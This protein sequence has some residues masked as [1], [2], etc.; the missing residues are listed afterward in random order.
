MY[1]L[2]YLVLLGCILTLSVTWA[3]DDPPVDSDASPGPPPSPVLEPEPAPA[4]VNED[5]IVDI[6]SGIV[7]TQRGE[8]YRPNRPGLG[9][10]Q[11]RFDIR[12]GEGFR[13]G[14]RFAPGKD[15]TREGMPN[16][17]L[18]NPLDPITDDDL[19][20]DPL[21]EAI[22]PG[23]WIGFA[24]S[25]YK[26]IRSPVKDRN[27]ARELCRAL[28][29]DLV[30]VT[31]KTEHLFL[32]IQLQSN[33][34]HHRTWY[35]SGTQRTTDVWENDG[36][37]TSFQDMRDAILPDQESTPY[38]NFLA[39]TY[40][41]RE[42]E[43]GLLKVDGSDDFPFICEISAN[44]LAYLIDE[45]L[46]HDHSYGKFISDPDKIPRGPTIV[47]QPELRPFDVAQRTN[48]NYISVTCIAEGY[49]HPKYGWYK[50]SYENDVAVY[51]EIDPLEDPRFTVS[52]GTLIINDPKQV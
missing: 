29:A 36:D 6:D 3:Q 18:S 52:G 33:D 46:E 25:C 9:Y 44:D 43:W 8:A 39:Y 38:K 47:R 40:S 11:D 31:D 14:D 17:M 2:R 35:T 7:Y 27:S 48:K 24:N 45:D 4:P 13:A 10:P 28:S 34:P 1:R 51:K 26:F 22:C 20:V 15:R 32:T 23:H 49:P 41:Y 12:P 19:V 37:G 50:E 5:R 30:S 16:T 42:N 21:K